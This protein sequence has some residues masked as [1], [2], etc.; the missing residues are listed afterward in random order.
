MRKLSNQIVV[1]AWDSCA[2]NVREIVKQLNDGEVRIVDSTSSGI[3][4]NSILTPNIFLEQILQA[5]KLCG[6]ADFLTYISGDAEC[7]NW[8]N[9]IDRQAS[10]CADRNPFVYSP[11]LTYEGHPAEVASLGKVPGDSN[12]DFGSATDGIVFTLHKEVVKVICDFINFLDTNTDQK[13][14]VGWGLDWAWNAFSIYSNQAIIRDS[15]I[16]IQHPKG[17]SYDTDFAENEFRQIIHQFPKFL[18][19][20]GISATEINKIIYKMSERAKGN[21]KYSKIADFY[22]DDFVK[23]NS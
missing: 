20:K 11:Y 14:Q 7:D 9:Y 2:G 12:L 1:V 15:K 4:N 3:L 5:C 10:V 21:P 17:T 6:E 18:E 8:A 19:S 13:Y 23:L 22:D 16:P